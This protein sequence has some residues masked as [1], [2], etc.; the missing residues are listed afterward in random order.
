VRDYLNSGCKSLEWLNGRMI[1]GSSGA[2]LMPC[3]RKWWYLHVTIDQVDVQISHPVI[4]GNYFPLSTRMREKKS[5]PIIL[6]MTFLCQN[7]SL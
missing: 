7:L 1:I 6:E 3:Q 2:R 5:R 4:G